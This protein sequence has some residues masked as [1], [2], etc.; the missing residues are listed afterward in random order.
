MSTPSPFITI[1]LVTR[2]G[3]QWLPSCLRSVVSQRLTDWELLILDN[4]S[5]DG[6]AEWLRQQAQQDERI[7]LVLVE[8]NTGY[9][10]AHNRAILA[11]R[12]EAVLLLNTLITCLVD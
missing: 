2:N 7:D 5:T 11:A 1:S 10:P 3:M 12:G 9:S 6:S 8:R 4:G